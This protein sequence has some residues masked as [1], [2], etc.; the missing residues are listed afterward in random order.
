MDRDIY[1]RECHFMS[2]LMFSCSFWCFCMFHSCIESDWKLE[3]SI[4][5]SIN[6]QQMFSEILCMC[7]KCALFLCSFD[8]AILWPAC[9]HGYYP[10]GIATIMNR[11]IAL[12]CDACLLL[13][14]FIDFLYF[15]TV[16]YLTYLSLRLYK[17]PWEQIFY[18]WLYFLSQS[19]VSFTFVSG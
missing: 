15:E 10:V 13:C 7:G 8:V 9:R 2:V 17:A 14:M 16:C 1:Y 5:C 11:T 19:R 4:Q 12:G 6:L 3:A 18:L